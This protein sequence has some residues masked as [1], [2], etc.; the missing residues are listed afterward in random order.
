MHRLAMTVHEFPTTP[1]LKIFTRQPEADDAIALGLCAPARWSRRRLALRVLRAAADH[2]FFHRRGHAGG[3]EIIEGGAIELAEID[4]G[5]ADTELAYRVAHRRTAITA[6]AG[7]EE[8]HR[9]DA[10]RARHVL[11]DDVGLAGQVRLHRT[12]VGRDAGRIVAAAQPQ[13]EHDQ[14]QTQQER[15]TPS[16]RLEAVRRHGERHQ[17]NKPRAD[18]R[19]A[20][21]ADFVK[22]MKYKG[23]VFQISALTR[24]GCEPLIKEIYK[25]IKA[26]Q[27][28]EQPPEYVDPRFAEP[29]S[30]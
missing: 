20:V 18:E 30:E 11:D 21:V 1:P 6:A 4:I 25:H 19:A 23:P 5:F 22:R 13:A 15:N 26:Q 7:L 2:L 3:H 14:H 24:E 27:V 29:T 16:P 12:P 10:A 8:H 28:S 9:A 17:R